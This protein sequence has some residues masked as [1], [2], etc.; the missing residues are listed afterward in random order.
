M[1]HYKCSVCDYIID[2]EK[3]AINWNSLPD[4]WVCPVCESP[5]T[6]YIL[7]DEA[8]DA[9]GIDMPAADSEITSDISPDTL[10][11]VNRVESYFDDINMIAETGKSIIEPMRTIK[12]VISWDDILIKG[13]QLSKLPLNKDEAVFSQTIIGPKAAHPLILETP[14]FV[15][16]MSFGALSK[17]AKIALAKGSASVKT[18]IGSGEGGILPDEFEHAY[19]YIFEYVPNHYS[20]SEENL[21]KSDAIEIK[22]GQSSK[23]GMGGHL[24]GDK[25]TADIASIRGLTEGV[26]IVSPS[27]FEDIQNKKDLAEKV[28]WLR[29]TSGG[30]PIGIKLAAGHIEADMEFA[31]SANPDFITLDGRAGST[32]ASPKFIKSATSVPSIFA[33]Y[34]ARKFLDDK[35]IKHISLII[36]GGLRISS[37]FVKALAMG[38]DAVAIGTTALIAIGCKQYRICHTGQCPMGITTQNPSLRKRLDIEKAATRLANFLSVS[39]EEL[40]EFARLTGNNNMH[41]FSISDLC[42][43]NS[44]ISTH[45]SIRHV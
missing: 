24:P 26:D 3:D 14:I 2:E 32:G 5:K 25:V 15:T 22:F 19:R 40:K 44:E 36:T 34:R 16:H 31:V 4:D 1:A 13:A 39:T 35:G 30:K 33:L 28:E 20:V 38:A 10:P 45:T 7:V 37:D 9:A 41:N 21:K 27:H 8:Y 17:E 12:P 11:G 23:P 18:A 43:T 6:Y 42:T 29:N